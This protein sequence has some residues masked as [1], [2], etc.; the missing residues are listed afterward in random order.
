MGD[1]ESRSKGVGQLSNPPLSARLEQEKES[2]EK[3]LADIEN[4]IDLLNKTPEVKAAFDAVTRLG[5]R[6]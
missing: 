3:R 5:I 6:I 2:L 1:I 4:A